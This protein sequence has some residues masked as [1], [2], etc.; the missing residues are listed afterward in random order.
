MTAHEKLIDEANQSIEDVAYYG[1]KGGPSA[2]AHAGIIAALNVLA[3]QVD[4]A[5]RLDALEQACKTVCPS[6]RQGIAVGITEAEYYD[7]LH[8]V[9]SD[10]STFACRAQ[11]IRAL[12]SSPVEGKEKA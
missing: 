7:G 3:S 9:W 1:S 2:G 5:A 12:S 4:Q 11:G 10:G 8:H 6:C